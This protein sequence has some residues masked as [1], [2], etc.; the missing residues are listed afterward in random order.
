MLCNVMLFDVMLGSQSAFFMDCLFWEGLE[1]TLIIL[2]WK[3]PTSCP[4]KKRR[5]NRRKCFLL[6]WSEMYRDL[7]LANI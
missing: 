3:E 2:L 6:S 1:I 5:S 7:T 4:D